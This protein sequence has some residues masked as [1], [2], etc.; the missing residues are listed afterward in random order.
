MAIEIDT[1]L[2]CPCN[3]KLYCDK[4]SLLQHQKTQLHKKNTLSVC[5]P[6]CR[7]EMCVMK[8]LKKDIAYLYRL[9]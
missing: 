8:N 9:N 1:R 2:V 4:Y 6:C 3:N 7:C 5:G